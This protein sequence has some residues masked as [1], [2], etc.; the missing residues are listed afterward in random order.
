[1]KAAKASKNPMMKTQKDDVL[2]AA[3]KELYP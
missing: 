2:N 1:M 3:T